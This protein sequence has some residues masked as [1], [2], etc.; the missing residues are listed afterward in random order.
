[1]WANIQIQKT[2]AHI[3][4]VINNKSRLKAQYNYEIWALLLL[5]LVHTMEVY[6]KLIIYKCIVSA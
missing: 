2:N 3:I 5:N 4:N 6:K 1:M